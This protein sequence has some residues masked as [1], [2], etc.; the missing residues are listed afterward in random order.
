[1]FIIETEYQALSKKTKKQSRNK[2]YKKE[3][4]CLIKACLE[5]LNLQGYLALRNNSGLVFLQENGKTRAIRMGIRGASD[6]IA[7]SPDGRFI[8]IECKTQKGRVTEMQ[9][10]FLTEIEKRGGVA[11]VIRSVD[12][13]I[14]FIRTRHEL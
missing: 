6:I 1:M 10:Q 11:L 12:E 13:L 4:S 5:V 14:D 7:C 2:K 3:E 8:A 9:K